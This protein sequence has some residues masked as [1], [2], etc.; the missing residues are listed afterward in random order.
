MSLRRCGF[1]TPANEATAPAGARSSHSAAALELD[2]ARRLFQRLS[3][4][5]DIAHVDALQQRSHKTGVSGLTA[6]EIQVIGLIA[7]GDTNR[8]I[9]DQLSI[10]ERTV[11]RHVSNILMK[12]HLPT[13]SAAT[14]YAYRHGLIGT[15]G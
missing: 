14:A 7:K 1:P 12:L 6:R 8:A 4:Q 11:D 9:A 5:P 15:T 2:A 10:S 3:A 13:R